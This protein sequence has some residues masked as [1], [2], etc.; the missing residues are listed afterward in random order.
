MRVLTVFL[1]RFEL[2]SDLVGVL[3][4]VLVPML[5]LVLVLELLSV[6]GQ[7]A[8]ATVFLALNQAGKRVALKVGQL[9]N[10][11]QF[12]R[13]TKIMNQVHHPRLVSA[14]SF[15]VVEGFA[16][17]YWIEMENLGG[18]TLADLLEGGLTEEE[19]WT[20][21]LDLVEGLEALHQ[22]EMIHRDLKPSNVLV[23]H[24]HTLKIS[25]FGLS[26]SIVQDQSMSM[27]AHGQMM[28]TPSYMSPEAI[29]GK[30]MFMRLGNG[31]PS[32]S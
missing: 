24:Q 23:G 32:M 25:D 27:S 6:L 31:I 10:R 30:S 16:P 1:Q 21:I 15:G 17:L 8:S 5:V 14:L 28:G 22:Q 29:S 11:K 9:T 18:Y 2:E 19:K 7:G 26:K 4:L 13:E 3:V 12:E 20:I